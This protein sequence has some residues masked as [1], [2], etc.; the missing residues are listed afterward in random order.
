MECP[1]C[2]LEIPDDSKF[3]KECG[4]KLDRLPIAEESQ[5]LA[6]SERKHVTILFSDLSGYTALTERFDPEEV[7]G[8][9]SLIFGKITE[10]I[11]SYD[12]FIE[13]FIGDAVMAVFGIP[14]AHEDDPVRGIKAAME[15]QAAV[16]QLSPQFESKIGRS[17]TMHTGINTG[18]V[19]TGE[20]DIE[21]GT[22]GLTGDAINLASRLESIAKAGEIVVGP[23]TYNQAL[24]FFE[25]ET[26]E[27]AKVKGKQQP[28]NIY[29]VHS[30]KKEFFKTYRLQGLQAALTGRDKEM[31]ILAKAAERLKQGQGSIISICGEAGTGKSRLKEEFKDF[32]DIDEI[33]WYEGHAYGYTQNMPYYPLINLL[34]HAFRIE[35]NDPPETIRKKLEDSVAYL[36]GEGNK[37]TPYI[38][39]LFAL[40]YQEIEK[41]SPEDWKD[42]LGKA[43]QAILTAIVGR[44]PTIVCFEDLH[45]ADPSFIKLF[46]RLAASTH[47]K[48]LFICTYRAHFTLF[49]GDPP[50]EL[51]DSYQ[52]FNIKD[53]AKL[54]AQEMLKSLLGTQNM[55][56]E[57]KEVVG[58]KTEGN[59]F[60]IE[61][62]INSLIESG[63]LTR[64]NG[65]WKLSRKITKA[66]IPA[67]IH[68]VLTARVDRLGKQF[69][70]IL[71]EASVIGRAFLFRILENIT[72]FD[73]G[74]D[75]YLAGLEGLDLIRTQ[76]EEPELE[77]IFK[78]VLTQEVVYKGLLK[79]ERQEIHERIGLAIEQIFADRLPEFYETLAHHFS[80]G[81]SA[82]KAIRY[83]SYSGE[84]CLNRYSLE[85]AHRYYQEAFNIASNIAE[86]S[87]QGKELLTDVLIKWFMVFFYQGD[88]KSLMELL[89]SNEKIVIS[90]NDKQKLGQYYAWLGGVFQRRLMIME[91]YQYLTKALKLG[92]ETGNDEVVGY[93][94]AWLIFT[95]ADM[96]LLDE[97][98]A[99]GKRAHAMFNKEKPN[100]LIMEMSWAATAFVSWVKG[101]SKHAFAASDV[102]LDYG[103]HYSDNR[104]TTMG[105]MAKGFG[106]SAEGDHKSAIDSFAYA[107]DIALDPQ[108]YCNC[109]FMLG[110]SY[111]A[112]ENL[113]EA[114]K[115][116][117]ELLRFDEEYG[118]EFLGASAKNIEALIELGNGRLKK[119]LNILEETREIY[120]KN[121][122]KLRLAWQ[123][124]SIGKFY[125]KLAERS[126]PM[127][128]LTIIKNIGFL[129][130]NV[131][132]ARKLAEK[133]LKSSIEL[134]EEIG[135]DF[136]LGQ[137][138]LDLGLLYKTMNQLHLA[139]SHI[140][141]ALS[142]F[143]KNNS[144]VNI[145]NAKSVLATLK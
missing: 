88:Y 73:S 142:I 83:L 119:G 1:E 20:V 87:M 10:I 114:E 53:L 84:K 71:Q 131:P 77:Y 34:S 135:S 63:I 19:V 115:V 110:W 127:G 66:D 8:I 31:T 17:L 112:D 49:E 126:G 12:G 14:K 22:H 143:D 32:L 69:K 57:L 40:S 48:A 103:R 59:P 82:V 9:M 42:R 128:F 37:H 68:G 141:E 132:F 136:I 93:S 23:E 65:I 94:C 64:D 78:H 80:K 4:C 99:F 129:I 5:P 116:N 24:N 100:S 96:G 81:K 133:Y 43:I 111:L 144:R 121:R 92:E 105:N 89:K 15:I 54:E 13:R 74:V 86:S 125:L 7:K 30:I 70:R 56:S 3:C 26:L 130:R 79:K 61:E 33:Q 2:Q 138:Q 18:L 97:A 11:K 91:S 50:D 118:F 117:S 102:L 145:D 85:E 39:S 29:K 109:R 67:T 123:E 90:L 98:I 124:H 58:Q 134:S 6:K 35:E 104:F 55:P 21:K 51:R 36:L 44:K 107:A 52:K 45:W 72:D 95:C 120:R 16:E 139:K 101:D 137:A 47:Q 60:Y 106:Y 38:G 25:F 46:E 140:E 122:A 27:P 108:F 28:V 113:K 62:M 76:S 41:A 75:K